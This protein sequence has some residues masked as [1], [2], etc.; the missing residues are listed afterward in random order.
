MKYRWFCWIVPLQHTLVIS[1]MHVL[2]PYWK[3]ARTTCTSAMLVSVK[4]IHKQ[5]SDCLILSFLTVTLQPRSVLQAH[6]YHLIGTNWPLAQSKGFLGVEKIKNPYNVPTFNLL[7]PYLLIPFVLV[8]NTTR[9]LQRTHRKICMNI[10]T[11]WLPEW[12]TIFKFM[13]SD[14][15]YRYFSFSDSAYPQLKLWLKYNLY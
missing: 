7:H 8:F 3:V 14:A 6:T 10:A 13:P 11:L 15:P 5:R 1:K 9:R 4:C 2:A 12:S